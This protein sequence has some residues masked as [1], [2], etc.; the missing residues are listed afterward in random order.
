MQLQRWSFYSAGKDLQPCCSELTSHM[1]V[2]TVIVSRRLRRQR[3]KQPGWTR[4]VRFWPNSFKP[5]E[6]LWTQLYHHY[7][8]NFH[9][10]ARSCTYLLVYFRCQSAEELRLR[11]PESHQQQHLHLPQVGASP[12]KAF[13]PP[14]VRRRLFLFCNICLFLQSLSGQRSEEP[15]ETGREE[16]RYG[17]SLW[18]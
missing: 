11:F 8:T 14:Q 12:F 17:R 2:D 16:G 10:P 3:L 9:P 7:S 6:V 5:A 18:G 15:E 13:R 1:G 4:S